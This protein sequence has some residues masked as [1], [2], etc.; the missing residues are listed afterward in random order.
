MKD[1]SLTSRIVVN[2]KPSSFQLNQVG[3]SFLSFLPTMQIFVCIKCK[4][5]SSKEKKTQT[6]VCLSVGVVKKLVHIYSGT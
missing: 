6:F 3:T 4:L 1:C 5:Y 2:V